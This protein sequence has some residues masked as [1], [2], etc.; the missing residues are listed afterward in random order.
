MTLG[1]SADTS[2]FVVDNIEY[3]WQNELKYKYSS[4]PAILVLCDGGGSNSAR[5]FIVKEDLVR[6][7]QTLKLDIVMAH[8]PP[9]CS[10][11]NPIEHRMFCHIHRT[12]EGAI[13]QNLQIVKELAE[14][15][16][17][18]NGLSIKVNI[19]EKQYLTKRKYLPE[20]KENIEN[21]IDF[22]NT[23]PKWNYTIKY[24]NNGVIY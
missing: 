9:Y 10:K 16:S 15:T 7:S 21:Y 22:N 18:Q 8:Y 14:K 24:K 1:T 17:T 11:W 23:I 4:A 3:F 19:N 2:E 13:F 5:H 6:L 12:W 20:F